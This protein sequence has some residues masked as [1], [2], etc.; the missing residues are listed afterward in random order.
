MVFAMLN[1]SCCLAKLS[2][3]EN[4]KLGVVGLAV[5]SSHF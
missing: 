5:V 4:V 2:D 1:C 3:V